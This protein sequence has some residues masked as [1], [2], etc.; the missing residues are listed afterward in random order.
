MTMNKQTIT[1]AVAGAIIGAVVV[2]SAP[3]SW[4]APLSSS[5][6]AF[7]RAT[8]SDVTDVYYRRYYGGYYGRRY[9]NRGAAI[10]LGILGAAA[11]AAAV[12]G[13]GYYGPYGPGYYGPSYGYYGTP[14]PYRRGYYYPY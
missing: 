7:K 14:Y 11:G 1:L 2:G 6:T 12:A 5:M 4:A 9:Y 8:L 13:S 10:G 3:P